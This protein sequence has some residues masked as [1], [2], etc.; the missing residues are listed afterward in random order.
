MTHT[1]TLLFVNDQQ[2]KILKFEVLRKQ[3]MS[4]DQDVDFARFH[5][6]ENDLLLFRRAETRNH[7]D[8]NWELFESLFEC[9]VVLKAQDR[10]GRKHRDLASV[11]NSLEGGAHGDF[12]FAI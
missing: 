7:L 2:A 1:K 4:A 5:A 12:S 6:F 3:A 9:L 10:G 8:V 11:L